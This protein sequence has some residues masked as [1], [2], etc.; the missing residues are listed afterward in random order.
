MFSSHD[1]EI[2]WIFPSLQHSKN[3]LES[4]HCSIRPV[5]L[6]LQE[7]D[8]TLG[9]EMATQRAQRISIDLYGS[10]IL[11]EFE[12]PHEFT[13]EIVDTS[14][15]IDPELVEAQN[16]LAKNRKL[17]RIL[18]SRVCHDMSVSVGYTFN[19]SVKQL[20]PKRSKWS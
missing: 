6:R 17:T 19:V 12:M 15:P 5:F 18:R 20:N 2:F 3:V 1:I 16:T 8:K 10:D 14:T 4:K 7:H 11:S 9:L 13:K